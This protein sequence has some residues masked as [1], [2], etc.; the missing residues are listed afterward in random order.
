[1]AWPEGDG[2]GGR[3]ESKVPL[4]NTHTEIVTKRNGSG[5]EKRTQQHI[6]IHWR[7]M[8]KTMEITAPVFTETKFTQMGD[9]SLCPFKER[10][11]TRPPTSA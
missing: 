6:L 10:N 8:D 2:G 1:M 11:T 4:P 9:S 5:K 7:G 3:Q